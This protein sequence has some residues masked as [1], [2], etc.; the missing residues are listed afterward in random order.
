[1]NCERLRA[2]VVPARLCLWQWCALPPSTWPWVALSVVYWVVLGAIGVTL[3]VALPS[4][5]PSTQ[6]PDQKTARLSSS[7][8]ALHSL[9]GTH[10]A[11]KRAGPNKRPWIPPGSTPRQAT[12]SRRVTRRVGERSVLVYK[13]FYYPHPPTT[14]TR[15]FWLQSPCCFDGISPPALLIKLLSSIFTTRLHF[16][17][18][19]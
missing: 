11:P 5:D 1:M 17:Y 15:F 6:P 7:A 10:G 2:S 4:H 9:H 12:S 19:R 13:T 3:L 16:S 14:R 8:V 18:C